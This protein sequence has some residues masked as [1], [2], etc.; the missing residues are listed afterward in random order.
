MKISVLILLE[1]SADVLMELVQTVVA[2]LV[3]NS[4]TR[5][6]TESFGG[7]AVRIPQSQQ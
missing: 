4:K 7:I 1:L 5:F 3:L 6:E 2:P